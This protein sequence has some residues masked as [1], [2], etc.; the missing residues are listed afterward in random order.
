M[1]LRCDEQI[2]D[3]Y[4][5]GPIVLADPRYMKRLLLLEPLFVINEDY[6]STIQTEITL[7]M[8]RICLEW[9]SEVS[10]SYS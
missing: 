3:T 2:A 7:E 4:G 1:D 6:F 5:N 9:L 10:Y 8:R